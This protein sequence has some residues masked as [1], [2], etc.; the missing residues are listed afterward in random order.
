MPA[1]V[2]GIHAFLSRHGQKDV[3]GRTK[4]GH[5]AV[6]VARYERNML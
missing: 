3:D 1:L 4:S 6:L 5:D 2:A